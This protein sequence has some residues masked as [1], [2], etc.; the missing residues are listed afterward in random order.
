M[1]EPVYPTSLSLNHC[2]TAHSVLIGVETLPGAKASGLQATEH[3]EVS[4]EALSYVSPM[5]F[6]EEICGFEVI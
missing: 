2:V 5:H 3:S 6:E 1:E 4:A